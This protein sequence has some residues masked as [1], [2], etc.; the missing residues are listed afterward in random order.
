MC[1]H[2]C[3]LHCGFIGGHLVFFFLLHCGF[4]LYLESSVVSAPVWQ[5]GI[6]GSIP[7]IGRTT[8]SD[9]YRFGVDTT[10]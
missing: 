4:I 8:F 7:S 9:E 1:T 5:S 10:S 3:S 2:I 6:Q